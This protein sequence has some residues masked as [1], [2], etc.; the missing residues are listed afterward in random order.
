[1]NNVI[2]ASFD[3]T[4]VGVIL[5]TLAGVCGETTGAMAVVTRGGGGFELQADPIF[6]LGCEGETDKGSFFICSSIHPKDQK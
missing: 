5:L 6:R 2:K 3:G 1:M 4:L